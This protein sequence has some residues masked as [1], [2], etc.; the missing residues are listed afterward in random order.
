VEAWTELDLPAPLCVYGTSKLCGEHFVRAYGDRH[1]II[2]TSGL[3]GFRRGGNASNFVEA[4][5]RTAERTG[6]V[7]VVNDQI[8]GPSYT[9]DVADA[10]ARL[11]ATGANGTFHITSAG[12]C[13]W[14]EFAVEILRQAGRRAVC[15]PI[16]SA[17]YGA[18]AARPPF[19]VLSN[20]RLMAA[21]IAQ[22]PRWQDG[23]ARYL[24]RRASPANSEP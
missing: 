11:I 4:I 5:L 2:R 15:T 7:R 18:K 13:T 12:R 22:P 1:L 17:E 19:S 23:L 10:T 21:G 8:V 9:A 6:Q 16:T 24:T 3:F 20:S 14:Y